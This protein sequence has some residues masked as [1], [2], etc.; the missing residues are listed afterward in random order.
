MMLGA[1]TAAWANSGAPLPYDSEVEW[2]S[3][4]S[5]TSPYINT[6]IL[7]A[8][9]VGFEVEVAR[10]LDL[11]SDIAVFGVRGYGGDT[12][13][14]VGAQVDGLFYFGWNTR[15]DFGSVDYNK[16]TLGLNFKNS[17]Q[18]TFDGVK[19]GDITS[20]YRNSIEL[21][22]PVYNANNGTSLNNSNVRYYK[23]YRCIITKG[24]DVVKDYRPVRIGTVGF[25][26]DSVSRTICEMIGTNTF[27]IG[28]DKVSQLGGG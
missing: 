28:P 8:D 9:D 10:T 19:C 16:H 17:R 21:K 7:S 14:F 3:S 13:F 5:M 6:G 24:I 27:T 20:T 1:R 12:R 23:Y 18:F 26:F 22:F 25:W 4:N 11:V 15:T 2:I